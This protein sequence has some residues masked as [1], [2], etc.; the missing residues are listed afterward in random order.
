MNWRYRIGT[1]SLCHDGLRIGAGYSGRNEG[2]NNPKLAVVADI[3]PIPPGRY[4]VGTA[5]EDSRLGPCVMAPAP[6]GETITFGRS[7]F[8]IHGDNLQHDTSHGCIVLGRLRA[9]P[10]RP[11][12]TACWR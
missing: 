2:R 3:G 11:V 12:L 4:A 10:S 6:K 8:R 5:Y 9:A 1:G 7:L